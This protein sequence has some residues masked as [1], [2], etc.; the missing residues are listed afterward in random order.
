M[1]KLPWNIPWKIPMKIKIINPN[2]AKKN[3]RDDI[4]H[5]EIPKKNHG[6]PSS[7]SEFQSNKNRSI[8]ESRDFCWIPIRI[9]NRFPCFFMDS[10]GFHDPKIR[11][12]SI[13]PKRFPV[14]GITW[15]PVWKSSHVP[16]TSR[17]RKYLSDL[18]C[19]SCSCCTYHVVYILLNHGIP[20]VIDHEML[21]IP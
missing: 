8:M 19:C 5:N 9:P 15:S 13:N 12:Q 21:Y 11:F 20:I 10:N 14:F 1:L 18:S 7:P 16:T 17:C 4:T 6:I 2:P 3:P